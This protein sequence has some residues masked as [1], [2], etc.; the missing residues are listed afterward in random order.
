MAVDRSILE[1]RFMSR[2]EALRRESRWFPP[3]GLSISAALLAGSGLVIHWMLLQFR[4]PAALRLPMTLLFLALFLLHGYRSYRKKIAAE[5]MLDR[6]VRNAGE[7][8]QSFGGGRRRSVDWRLSALDLGF[9]GAL[10]IP[11]LL[12]TSLPF[13]F[14]GEVLRRRRPPASETAV[15]LAFEVV[16]LDQDRVGRESL[17]QHSSRGQEVERE[18]IDLLL[19]MKLFIIKGTGK[20]LHL[21]RTMAGQDFVAE[22]ASR[23]A[24]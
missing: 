13:F 9:S 12:M 5:G 22:S 4:L 23:I 6:I 2:V 17:D 21:L 19:D 16:A 15:R 24:S 11:L 7:G 1:R 20:D 10:L 14:L 18:A 8:R 3:V